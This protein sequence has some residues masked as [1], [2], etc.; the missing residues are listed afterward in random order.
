MMT[1]FFWTQRQD[2]GPTA[3]Q[4]HAMAFDP[5]RR[6][7]VLYGGTT[8]DSGYAHDTWEWD[9]QYWTQVSDMGPPARANHAMAWDANLSRVILFGCKHVGMSVP[10][11]DT[12]EWDGESWTQLTDEGPGG[13]FAFALATFTSRK[14]IVLFGGA[15]F[16]SVGILSALGD[17]WEWDGNIWEQAEGQLTLILRCL[18][19]CT[20][21]EY[22]G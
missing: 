15:T 9:G 21:A 17:T 1:G 10:F 22:D 11:A 14:R 18:N 20:V 6:K 2:I 5:I 8:L 13:R 19:F 12:W 16:S 4:G 3:R 7:T